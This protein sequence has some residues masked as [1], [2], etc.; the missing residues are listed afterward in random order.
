MT[1]LKYIPDNLLCAIEYAKRCD[2]SFMRTD[3]QPYLP[4]NKFTD[5]KS[6]S[7][8]YCWS[9]HLNALFRYLEQTD[10]QNITLVS[11]DNDHPSN[12]NGIIISWPQHGYDG[13]PPV[14]KCVTRWFA[15][16]AEV[17]NSIMQPIPIGLG[18][19]ANSNDLKSMIVDCRRDKLLYCNFEMSTNPIQRSKIAEIIFKSCPNAT[20]QHARISPNLFYRHLQEHKFV[21]CPPGNGKDTHRAWESLY[22]GAIPVVEDSAMNRY[23]STLFPMVVVSRWCDVTESFLLDKYEEQISNVWMH[24]LLDANK[25][26][27]WFQVTRKTS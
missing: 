13:I 11:G 6:N 1:M 21:L 15:Q 16:N 20:H 12:P 5:I 14:P 3:V 22:F 4:N 8:V 9:S 7:S 27:N 26:M 23:F 24:E 25:L 17:H 10:L 18:K 19:S 2:F